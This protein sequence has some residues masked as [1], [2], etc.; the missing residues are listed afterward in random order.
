MLVGAMKGKNMMT[1][2]EKQ[3][4]LLTLA[5]G[6]PG[7]Q[8]GHWTYSDYAALDDGQRYEIMNGVL[9]MTPAPS[10]NH[11]EVTLEI[12][13]HLRAY[14]RTNILGEYSLLLTLN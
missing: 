11:Q 2:T 10:W 1:T 4:P 5:G 12:A 8:Q 7:P 14:L 13:T 6:A 9:L 3:P